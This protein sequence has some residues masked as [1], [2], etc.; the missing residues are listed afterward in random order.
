MYKNYFALLYLRSRGNSVLF[1]NVLILTL[2]YSFAIYYMRRFIVTIPEGIFESFIQN[3]FFVIPCTDIV[4][5]SLFGNIATN[6][7]KQYKTLLINNDRIVFYILFIN[8]IKRNNFL[9][10]LIILPIFLFALPIQIVSIY[11]IV[12]IIYFIIN[13]LLFI[14]LFLTLRNRLVIIILISLLIAMGFH[15]DLLHFLNVQNILSLLNCFA[16]LTLFY[17][18]CFVLIKNK[19]HLF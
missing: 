2:L 9:L 5:K 1:I 14:L 6:Q 18:L 8:I 19:Y 15:F 13:H 11:L 17:L 16:I 12:L 10:F 4:M 7:V 3:F